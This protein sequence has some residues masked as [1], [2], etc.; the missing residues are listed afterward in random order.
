MDDNTEALDGRELLDTIDGQ[1]ALADKMRKVH[2]IVRGRYGFIHRIAIAVYDAEC[3]VL[4]AFVNSTDTANPLPHYQT[5]LSSAC[6]LAAVAVSGRP[7]VINDLSVFDGS[8]QKHARSLKES[9]YQASYTVPMFR[10][11]QLLGFVFFN[12]RQ[13]EV[14]DAHNLR[15]LD[16]VARLLAL[17]IHSQM[18]QTATLRGALKTA[19]YFAHH[20]DPETGAHLERMARYARLIANDIAGSR[21]LS[22]EFVESLF[23]FAPLHDI[24]KIAIPDAILLKPG[25]LDDSEFELM[26]THAATGREMIM[27]MLNNFNVRSLPHV[28]MVAN[29]AGY[30]H[31]NVDG[32]GYPEGIAGQAIPIEAQIVAVADVFDALTSE[33]PYKKAW[34]NAE[35]FRELHSLAGRKFDPELVEALERNID[36]VL[37]IQSVFVDQP[38]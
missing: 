38:L 14:F 6:S 5:T 7:R 11:G 28:E 24:G 13:R 9:G 3:D 37:T 31:E 29:I 26:K 12:S 10:D 1:A 34:S 27:T 15:Y 17:M 20:R 22:E 2:D 18:E 33:R 8:T 21:D 36:S 19:T 35:A 23:H 16:M 25:R 32:S 4:K 30:H